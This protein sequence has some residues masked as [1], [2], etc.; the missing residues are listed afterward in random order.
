MIQRLLKRSSDTPTIRGRVL[1]PVKKK[2]MIRELAT[3]APAPCTARSRS[4]K[5]IVAHRG[6][7]RGKRASQ[8]DRPLEVI[9][10]PLMDGMKTVGDLFGAGKMFLPQVVK[11]AR[12][13]KRPWPT[14]NLSWRPKKKLAAPPPASSS[15]PPSRATCTT[16]A[17][18]S[19][20]SSSPVTTTRSKT[21]ESWSIATPSSKKPKHGAP[22]SSASPVSSRPRS[23]R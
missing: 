11:S 15:S 19:L 17:K 4:I 12:V 20:P 23:T 7:H 16:S 3:G 10:G 21:S 9:E 14:C 13:M 1:A 2:R 22:T 5:G 18:T 8:Y 6:R